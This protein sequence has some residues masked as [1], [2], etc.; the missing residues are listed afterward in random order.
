ML[1]SHY[2]SDGS[3]ALDYKEFVAILVDKDTNNME[4]KSA[5]FGQGLGYKPV[6]SAAAGGNVQ[7]ILAKVKA[8][9]ASRGARGLIGM[10][11]QFK[12]F[13]DDNSRSLD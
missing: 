3:G 4:K 8:K 13:D 12:I 9:L 7:E 6:A 10:G 2:D 11:K 5:Q 1:F